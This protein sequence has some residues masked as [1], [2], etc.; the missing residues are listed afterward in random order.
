MNLVHK[1][2]FVEVWAEEG[3]PSPSG[4]EQL[5]QTVSLE[6][7]DSSETKPFTQSNNN[8]NN[9]NNQNNNNGASTRFGILWSRNSLPIHAHGP[10]RH[11]REHLSGRD[12]THRIGGDSG[13]MAFQQQPPGAVTR[14]RVG[15]STLAP[16]LTVTQLQR[17]KPGERLKRRG[18]C[19]Q[20]LD[21]SFCAAARGQPLGREAVGFQGGASYGCGGQDRL[22]LPVEK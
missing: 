7:L 20:P 8:N 1:L 19:L 21:G 12:G 10:W 2:C 16:Q 22:R 3:F 15:P 5:D 9:N 4:P 18:Q 6:A 17:Q 11:S 14:C 13:M